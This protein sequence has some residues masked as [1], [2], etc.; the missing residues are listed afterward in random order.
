[1][2]AISTQMDN[3]RINTPMDQLKIMTAKAHPVFSLLTV[4]VVVTAAAAVVAGS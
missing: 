1:M 3:F 2:V 4:V